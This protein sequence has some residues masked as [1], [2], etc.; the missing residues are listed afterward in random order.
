MN[1]S[2]KK[3]INICVR[4]LLLSVVA[5]AAAT[6]AMGVMLTHIIDNYSL[7]ADQEGLM[8]S[9]ISAG[10][11]LALIVGIFLRG[12]IRKARFILWGGSLMA[13]MLLAKSLPVPF[14]V[15]LAFC[16]L[17]GTGMGVADS[18]QSSLLTDLTPE[19]ATKSLGLL[20]GIFGLGGFA[21]PLILHRL[22][23]VA[24]WRTVYRLLGVLD[25]L[26]ILQFA[27]VILKREKSMPVLNKLE[28]SQSFGMIGE[29]LKKPYF[30]VLL[31]S[32]ILGAMAQNGV[33]V[34]VV[35][36]VSVHL[37]NGSLAPF[38]LSLFWIATSVSRVAVPRL[39]VKPLGFLSCGSIAAG[40]IWILGVVSG[41]AAVM[42]LVSVA[43]G[44]LSG[45]CMPVLLGEGAGF[46]KENTGLTTNV[47]MMVKTTGQILMPMIVSAVISSAGFSSAMI[48][49]GC[50][51]A[52]DGLAV[53]VLL[54]L[55][56]HVSASS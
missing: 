54:Q 46:N 56:M 11:F 27:L 9:C 45:C 37:G 49:T 51:F 28:P 17:M 24:S 15:F 52:A 38:C 43:A 7:A 22:L 18:F 35:R 44:L 8:S 40:L 19:T 20:H 12:K 36:Y 33:I 6:N 4:S 1:G 39:P 14:Y 10:A 25:I 50:V 3:D 31:L 26:L 42:L 16:F 2:E 5:T 34:W 41:R 13:V 48:L 47:L 55:K 21:L 30:L 32:M 23:S 53:L 29:F